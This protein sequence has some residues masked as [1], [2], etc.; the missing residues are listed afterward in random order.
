MP[1]AAKFLLPSIA[2]VLLF[3]VPFEIDGTKEVALGIIARWIQS[4]AG[5]HMRTFCAFVFITSGIVTP[6]FTCGPE[7]LRRR[8]PVFAGVF[9]TGPYSTLMRMAGAVF[10]GLTF[11]AIGPEWVVDENTGGMSYFTIAGVIFCIIGVG[12]LLMPLL[13][14]Y[15]LLEMIGTILRRPFRKIFNLPGR[16]T[17][18]A[19][20]S[21]VG[22]SSIAVLVTARQY[23]GGFYTAR[24]ASVIATNFS[25]VS[26]PFVFLTAQVA[27]I[28]ELSGTLYITMVII[29]VAC[30]LITPRLPPL[31]RMSDEYYAPIGRQ[32]HEEVRGEMSTWQWARHE[33]L[34]R[35]AKGPGLLEMLS[36]GSRIVLDLFFAMMPVAMTI[37][38][39]A[40]AVYHHTGILHLITMPLVPLLQLLAIPDAAAAAPGLVVGFLDQFVP[41][42]IAASIASPVTSFV[43]AGLSVTQLIFMAETG[44]LIYR[45]KIPLPIRYLA[46]VF[47]IRTAIALPILVAVAHWSAG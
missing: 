29:G 12:A 25:V 5:D 17:I 27:G 26:V 39:I 35:A 43:L 45:S 37:E 41:A 28:A 7:S 32:V 23:R 44:I 10:C 18:D 46:A 20:A 34:A 11:W 9:V 22:A 13:T 19:L 3:L 33:A 24:E 47:A 21:W 31:N 2:G 42:L 16:S 36:S 14:D 38:F 15:G 1:A 40:L 4:A 30:A 6:L 8:F